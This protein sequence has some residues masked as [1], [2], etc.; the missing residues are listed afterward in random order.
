MRIAL[1]PIMVG[2]LATSLPACWTPVLAAERGQVR[3]NDPAGATQV[4]LDSGDTVTYTGSI[5]GAIEASGAGNSVSG[6]N[7]TVTA[8][9]TVTPLLEQ[10]KGVR[11]SAGATVSLTRSTIQ[12]LGDGQANHALQSLGANS[13]ITISDSRITTRGNLSNGANAKQGGSVV[14]NGG[15]VTT[16]G[17]SAIALWAEDAGSSISANGVTITTTG[18][19]A[20]A[21]QAS[22]GATITLTGGSVTALGN[23]ASSG[24]E[25]VGQN[26]LVSLNNTVVQGGGDHYGA[27]LNGGRLEMDGGSLTGGLALFLGADTRGGPASTALLKNAALVSTGSGAALDMNAA[28]VSAVLENTSISALSTDGGGVWLAKQ[29]TQLTANVFDITSTRVGVDNRLGRAVLTD[30]TIKTLGAGGHGL[31]VS[32]EWGSAALIDATRV[33]IETQG[34]RASGAE[35][36]LGD[37]NSADAA[38]IRLKDSRITT[39]GGNAAGLLARGVYSTLSAV[40]TDIKTTGANSAGLLTSER[41]T[42]TLDNVRLAT[43]GAGAVGIW[44]TLENAGQGNTI[45]VRNG[46]TISTQ[47]G[48]AMLANGGSHTFDLSDATVTGRAGGSLDNGVLL[49]TNFLRVVSGGVPTDTNTVLVSLNATRSRLTGDVVAN[50]GSAQVTLASGS[51]LT[52]ALQERATGHISMALDAT[53]TWNVRGDS[54]L[55]SLDNAGTVAYV[56]PTGGGGFKTVTVNHYAGGGTLVLNTRLGDDASATDKLVIDSG[57]TTGNTSLRILNSG[58]AGGQTQTGIRVIQTIN[59]GT[60]AADAFRLDAGST[61]YRA[62]AQT[63][64]LNGYEYSLVR[65]GNGG[66]AADWYLTSDFSGVTPPD[67]AVPLGPITPIKPPTP[68]D[69]ASRV[70]PATPAT[71]SPL[72]PAVIT[73]SRPAFRNVS[74]ES[75][76]YLGNRLASAQFFNHGRHDRIPAN[77][78]AVAT[79]DAHGDGGGDESLNDGTFNNGRGVWTRVLGRQDSGVRLSQGRVTLDT[80]S[81]ILQ[82]GG[83]LINAPLGQ[84]GAVYAGLMGGYGDARSTSISALRL[85]TG[86]TVQARARGKVSGYSVGMYGTVYQND[87]TRMGAYADTWLQYGRYSNQINSELGS[88]RYHSTVWSAALEAGYAVKPFADSS[89]L[90]PVVIEPHA[91][92][93]YSRYDAQ[94]AT[95][96]GTRMRSGN[97][98]AWNSRVGIRLYPQAVPNAPAVRPFLEANWLHSFGNP[99]VNMGPNTLDAALARNSLELKLG[100]EGR[101]SRRVQ[102]AGHVFG[103]AGNNNQR[104]YGGML[105]VGYRW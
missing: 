97:D 13:R 21:V 10:S 59:G 31:Y 47:D 71:P 55:A 36:R 80:D 4:T 25:I 60:T 77:P 79:G 16:S 68:G 26:S 101:V 17:V 34:N 14:I 41:A 98:N 12:T 72:S 45:T 69:P 92:L 40:N 102:V 2:L 81:A 35:V 54:S 57:A 82:L 83:D 61:G 39:H 20:S 49:R 27:R 43:E 37:P 9:P 62:S 65:G 7:I 44:S 42:T 87:A 56:A 78:T 1:N 84:D 95:L 50:D 19:D 90:G 51:V 23:Y 104:G 53:S 52:G 73:P 89:S 74:P 15:S 18:D 3:V 91:Q 28:N 22:N 105:N 58:G 29:G 103:Q 8:N 76:A 93:V 30:G 67:P 64:A 88:T 75:G 33:T 100:A 32:R 94:D 24:I 96:Q 6:D 66:V 11:A 5:E 86:A 46:T 85:P 48:A 99:S 70:D 63:L 38:E